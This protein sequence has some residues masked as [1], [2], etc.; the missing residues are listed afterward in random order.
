MTDKEICRLLDTDAERGLYELI[1]KYEAYVKSIIGRV[2]INRRQDIEECV[3]DTF[4][5]VW[6]KRGNLRDVSIKG[7]IAC[8]ARNTAI[9][10]Y[11]RLKRE[12]S[13]APECESL[14]ADDEIASLIEN[15]YQSE[16]VE[17][18]LKD[19]K[20]EHREIFLRRHVLMESVKEI[21]DEMKM[22]E[23][24][25]RNSLYRSKQ[26]LRKSQKQGG[27]DDGRSFF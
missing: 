5:S 16:A 22:D 27:N 10:R 8:I 13:I 15:I 11:R 3:E 26:K 18:I 7:F 4:L 20:R 12:A 14:T 23:R 2:L 17:F 19:L 9:N 25:V 24:S 21:S 1:A 6:E